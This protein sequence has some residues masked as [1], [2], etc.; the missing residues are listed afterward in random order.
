MRNLVT[1]RR[2]G[3]ALA[4][5]CLAVPLAAQGVRPAPPVPGPYQLAPIPPSVLGSS[6]PATSG[7]PMPAPMTQTPPPG[8]RLPYWMTPPAGAT[9]TAESAPAAAAPNAPQATQP[10]F[11]PGYGA[12]QP[13][14]GASAPAGAT[15][16]PMAPQPPQGYQQPYMPQP[17]G[18]PPAWGWP[19]PPGWAPMQPGGARQ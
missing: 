12:P 8:M 2:A 14:G 16:A 3:A 9:D 17:Y 18:A 15:R 19:S 4:L 10:G 1:L 5:I 6:A 13:G 7:A 11:F